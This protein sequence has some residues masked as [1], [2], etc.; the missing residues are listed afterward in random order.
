MMCTRLY[1]IFAIYLLT[2]LLYSPSL[3]LMTVYKL[4]QGAAWSAGKMGRVDESRRYMEESV[5]A[6]KMLPEF[7]LEGLWVG[8]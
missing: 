7:N 6:R 2:L 3:S 1:D 5:R 4:T 8:K